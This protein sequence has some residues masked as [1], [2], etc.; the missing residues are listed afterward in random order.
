VAAAQLA[1]LG[2]Q[3]EPAIDLPAR[4]PAVAARA[5]AAPAASVPKQVAR[6]TP[7]L[8]ARKLVAQR[9]LPEVAA[10][11]DRVLLPDFQG[12]SVAEV[13]QITARHG[14][15]VEIS[16]KGRAIAQDPPPGTVVAARGVR[17]RVR[18]RAAGDEI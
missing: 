17:V 18:F 8:A 11:G 16:G 14:L 6:P 13:R 3:T 12:L 9:A 1:R 2:V 4:T 7:A 15:R 10:I 5:P